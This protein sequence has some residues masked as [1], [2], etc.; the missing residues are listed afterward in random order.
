MR[1]AERE[2]IYK[3]EALLTLVSSFLSHS[4]GIVTSSRP[5]NSTF[6]ERLAYRAQP[7]AKPAAF[8]ERNV[9]LR[10]YRGGLK[11]P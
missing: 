4:K 3:P 2:R 8:S 10:R 5:Q 11:G 6:M 1:V 9:H 7:K